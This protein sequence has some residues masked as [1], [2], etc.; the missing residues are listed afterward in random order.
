MMTTANPST[1]GLR[2]RT[3]RPYSTAELVVDAIVH[4]LGLIVAIAAGSILLALTLMGTAPEAFPAL[5]VY[6]STL[7]VVLGVSLASLSRR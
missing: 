5:V 2:P 1:S 6:V 4:V 3:R 7:V